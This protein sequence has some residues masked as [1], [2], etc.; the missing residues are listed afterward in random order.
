MQR[1]YSTGTGMLVIR[2]MA[3][4]IP[5]LMGLMA[6]QQHAW[7][8]SFDCA[9]ARS[10]TEKA[11]CGDPELSKLDEQ[12][13]AAYKAALAIHPLPSCVRS[14]QVDWLGSLPDGDTE[15]LKKEFRSRIDHLMN[16]REVMVYSDAERAFSHDGGDDAVELWNVGGKWHLSVWGG[17][18]IN[19]TKYYT[20]E[21]EGTVTEPYKPNGS[22]LA[23]GTGDEKLSFALT[24]GAFRFAGA[25]DICI[26][27]GSIPAE[28]ELKRVLKK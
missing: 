27:M 6:P 19:E 18:R 3:L 11:I 5:V 8:A 1:K 10:K 9:K 7:A 25:P 26:G 16:A 28:H 4:L 13:A 2:R 14:R 15:R 12:L 24:P 23:V 22:N 17:G 20:C 21:F